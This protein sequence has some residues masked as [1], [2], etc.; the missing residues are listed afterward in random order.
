MQIGFACMNANTC[1]I[2]HNNLPSEHTPQGSM[3][4]K[5]LFSSSL[6]E[7]NV[8]HMR[9]LASTCNNTARALMGFKSAACTPS[10]FQH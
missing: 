5:S 8:D 4:G 6:A 7:G 9:E 2:D 1:K 3:V 10:L